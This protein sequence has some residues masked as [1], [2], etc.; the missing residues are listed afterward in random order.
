MENDDARIIAIALG[1]PSATVL[2]AALILAV[3]LHRRVLQR[4][5][6]ASPPTV[7]TNSPT[8]PDPF[9]GILLERRA[10]RI[11]A[12]IPRHLI[13]INDFTRIAGSE[14]MVESISPVILEERSPTP[15]RRCMPI[16]V[17][18]PSPS[19]E[20]LSG[21]PQSPSPGEYAHY[22]NNGR[23]FEVGRDIRVTTPPTLDHTWDANPPAP[24]PPVSP[25]EFWD[26]V[27]IPLSAYLPAPRDGSP[28]H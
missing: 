27:T 23:G 18:S 6:R 11:I 9:N 26:N 7:P 19:T 16:I 15:P 4:I 8:P 13:L 5:Q 1:I 25:N 12:P 3:S 21:A 17:L 24:L 14:E 10:P 2:T 28:N 22:R 20:D